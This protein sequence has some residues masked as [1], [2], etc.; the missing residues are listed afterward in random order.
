MI[1]GPV[2]DDGSQIW[3]DNWATVQAWASLSTQWR[4]GPSGQLV[5]LDYA[6][7]MPVLELIGIERAEWSMVFGGLR[8]MEHEVLSEVQRRG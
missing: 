7:I 1:E 8:Q 3:P 6:A 4:L 2:E 5:G